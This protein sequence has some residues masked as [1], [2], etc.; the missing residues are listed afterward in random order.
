MR[1]AAITF[2]SLLVASSGCATIMAGGPDQVPIQTNPPGATVYVNGVA[3]GQTP[4]VVSLNRS[5]DVSDIRIMAAGFQPVEMQR[6]KEINGWFWA[7]LCWGVVPMIIDVATGDMKRFDDTPIAIGLTPG[8]DG[9]MTP[10]M[11]YPPGPPPPGYPPGPNGGMQ[12]GAQP[13]GYP[14]AP[15]PPTQP[16]PAPYPPAGPNTQPSNQP[17]PQPTPQGG[18]GGLGRH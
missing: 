9:S 11:G 7:N 10:G 6:Y 13:G 1:I 5:T 15:Y 18:L 14:A 4:I 3:V 12:P 16:G 8:G 17:P 2:S